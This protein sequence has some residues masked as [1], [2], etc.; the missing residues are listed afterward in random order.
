MVKSRRFE[1]S[2]KGRFSFMQNP[3]SC[4]LRPINLK[5][6]KPGDSAFVD[7]RA[8]RSGEKS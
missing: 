1:I 6:S 3:F 7:K 8:R 2:S 5:L 4:Y